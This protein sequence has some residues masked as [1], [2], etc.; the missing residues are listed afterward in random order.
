MSCEGR[1]L[2]ANGNIAH[3]E[4]QWMKCDQVVDQLL[5]TAVSEKQLLMDMSHKVMLTHGVRHGVSLNSILRL[6]EIM[7]RHF[8]RLR[9]L[10]YEE[11]L[12]NLLEIIS[13][14]LI[15]K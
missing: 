13:D 3:Q 2:M 8:R 10:L 11:E 4:E 1:P 6:P 9:F 15:M 14:G 7:Q 5:S 12:V